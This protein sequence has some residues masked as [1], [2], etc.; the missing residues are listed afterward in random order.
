MN[1]LVVI[2]GKLQ[3]TEV[4][5][6]AR[7]AGLPAL[8]IDRNPEALASHLADEFTCLDL[9]RDLDGFLNLLQKEDLVLP[10]MENQEVL[11]LLE[12]EKDRI[13]DRCLGIAFD[14]DAYRISSSKEKSDRIF[15][16][17]GLPAPRYYP[18]G[19]FPYIGKPDRGS[20][21]EGVQL[22]RDKEELKA[23]QEKPGWIL[24]EYLQ[25]PSYSIEVTG[26]PGCYKTHGITRIH[27][28][29]VF[30]CCRVTTPCPLS[31]AERGSME[32]MA[33]RLAEF[34]GLKGIMDLEVI[35]HQGDMK[36]LEI[37]ARMPSQTPL[38]V[39]YSTGENLLIEGI[40]PFLP[41]VPGDSRIHPPRYVSYE[42]Y[43]ISP[44]GLEQMGE[45][46]LS[47]AGPL[48]REE[49]Q[50][51]AGV[52]LSDYQEGKT[53]WQGIF[54][55]W[56]ESLEELERKRRWMKNLLLPSSSG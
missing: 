34:I 36:L 25:G 2:G 1:R 39:F 32:E 11:D 55:N 9:I 40:R 53:Q 18:E 28:D 47:D 31:D 56:G 44:S 16:Q 6:L 41:E 10:A 30:D 42:H 26:K 37:D 50:F 27:M 23:F 20:G 19:R 43:R 12:K 14:F 35:H 52:V 5:T 22:F 38:A 33:L 51:G 4:V 54:I 13:Q 49:N 3:G 24:Q 8:L 7:L 21:S 17:L 15:H 46:I 45:H 48:Q 29:P